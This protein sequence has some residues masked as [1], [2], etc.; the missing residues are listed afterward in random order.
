MGGRR[1]TSFIFDAAMTQTS[2]WPNGLWT[3]LPSWNGRIGSVPRSFSCGSNGCAP[4]LVSGARQWH[5]PPGREHV[6]E[7]LS[8]SA[9]CRLL[10]ISRSTLYRLLQHRELTHIRIGSRLRFAECDIQSFISKHRTSQQEV[11]AP[12]RRGPRVRAAV[13]N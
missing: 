3:S 2:S 4:F 11:P 1:C 5:A 6:T 10:A 13:A 12:S 8:V 9:V 7:L